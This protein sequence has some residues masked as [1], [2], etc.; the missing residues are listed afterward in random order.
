MVRKI[1]IGIAAILALGG[2]LA[3]G[4]WATSPDPHGNPASFEDAE[5]VPSILPLEDAVTL[6][7]IER[8]SGDVA[9]LLVLDFDA[10]EASVV[11]L[12]T[13]G[14]T[15]TGSPF[16]VLATI[17]ASTLTEQVA[18]IATRE[19][20]AIADLLPVAG[21]GERHIATG[22]NFPE[23]AEEASS[24]QVFNFPKFG[25]ATPARTT[26]TARPDM[27]LDY[28]IEMCMIFDRP[29]RSVEDFDAAEKGFFLC[30][31]FTDRA[32]LVR[33]VDP[34]NL[35]SGHGFSDAKSGPDFYPSG[36]F[37]VIPQDW[38]SFIAEE[39]MTTAVNDDPR[40]DARGG[41]M[42]LDF[43]E[44]TAQALT[45]M[46]QPR[47]LYQDS[48]H[49]LS[50]VPFIATGMT[51][52]SGTSEGVIFTPPTRGDIIEGAVWHL[53][54]GRLFSG[55][56]VISSVIE[57]FLTNEVESGQFLQAGDVVHYRSSSMGDIVIEVE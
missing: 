32:T 52:M 13:L 5:L 41:E 40:Q 49:R 22:T 15:A 46:D 1:A 8:P 30:G 10:T 53:F 2:L 39:R 14:S 56:T 31:D 20:V 21:A 47:F 29:I 4:L 55:E 38:Q 19:T 6:A 12:Q 9:T 36:P 42:T 51:L 57:V 7:Q 23:H 48:Y 26:V 50:P 28:E 3:I 43:R 45:D 44:L 35:D 54:S 17:D 18:A 16:E 24:D 11:D 33:L 25:T 37:L 27:L 34:D